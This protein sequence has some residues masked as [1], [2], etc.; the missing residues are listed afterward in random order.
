MI[1]TSKTASSW[2]K[3]MLPNK[4]QNKNKAILQNIK[5][6]QKANDFSFFVIYVSKLKLEK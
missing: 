1:P 6:L 2:E 3:E 5:D 4:K